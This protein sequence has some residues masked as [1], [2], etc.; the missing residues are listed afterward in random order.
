[1][2]SS[3]FVINEKDIKAPQR[4]YQHQK[5]RCLPKASITILV[6]F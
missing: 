2:P 6:V 4:Q 1:M 3:E 5:V